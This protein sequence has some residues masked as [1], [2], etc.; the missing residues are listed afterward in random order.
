MSSAKCIDEK[1][2]FKACPYRIITEEHKAMMIGQ[3]DIISQLFYPCIGEHCA[4]YHIGIC[5][6][7]TEVLQNQEHSDRKDNDI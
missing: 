4:G 1:G 7:L 5:L 3:G 2:D 6:R